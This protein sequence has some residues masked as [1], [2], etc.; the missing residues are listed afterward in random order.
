MQPLRIAFL[1]LIRT[2]FDVPLA[3]DMIRQ[4]RASLLAAGYALDGP[5]EPV[6]SLEQAQAAAR[7]LEHQPPDL[8]LVYQATFA[9]STLVTA[10]AAACDTPLLLWAV[11]ETWS[12]GRLRLNSLCGVTLAGHALSLRGRQYEW[13]CA[14]P[15]DA[16][17]LRQA[18]ALAAAGA[19]RR[20]LRSTCLGVVGEHPD[21]L[22]TCRL[23]ESALQ[24]QF[25]VRVRRIGLEAAFTRAR[26]IP[27]AELRALRAALDARLS[28]LAELEQAPLEGTLGAFLA[29]RA[30]AH[31][32]G[33]D[34][35]AVR[36]WPEF[37][38][39]LGCAACGAMSL[40]SD[41]FQMAAPLPCSCEADINGTLTQW[42]LQT[43]S[44]SPAFGTD[45]VGLDTSGDRMAL[46][47]CGLAPLS[48][49]GPGVVPRGGVHSN[50]KLPLVMDFPL[51]AGAVTLARVSQAGGGLRLVYGRGQM[52]AEPKPFSGTAGVLQPACGAG[53]FFER[54]MRAG[55]EH[56]ISL[57]YGDIVPEL[58]AFARL[59]DL[60]ELD[61]DT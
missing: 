61:L 27:S 56:H 30:I 26:S 59:I 39:Q 4:A 1:P 8:L 35:L 43:L 57:V 13:I 19:L 22:D 23:D 44:G 5:A 2:T 16:G 15:D 31:E 41:G 21:G 47:H 53:P 58:R 42:I 29:L 6:T 11:P 10:L 51:K 54:W 34:G 33:L 3:E 55:L 28:N 52:L 12:G 40:L 49:A 50:R 46:W 60:P 25:G 38:T 20:R 48:M 36:C 9:D 18:R 37:F 45:I 7:A 14:S 32:Q 17:A 24:A